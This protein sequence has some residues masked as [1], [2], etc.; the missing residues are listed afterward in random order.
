MEYLEI[1]APLAYKMAE[2][3][4]PVALDAAS[5]ADCDAQKKHESS[6]DNNSPMRLRMEKS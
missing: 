1:I 2:A 6:V 5:L 3:A 4:D